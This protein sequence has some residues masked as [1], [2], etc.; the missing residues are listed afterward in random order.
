MAMHVLTACVAMRD[1]CGG[2][3]DVGPKEVF[4]VGVRGTPVDG[5]YV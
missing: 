1:K 3:V 5:G 2:R 4:S